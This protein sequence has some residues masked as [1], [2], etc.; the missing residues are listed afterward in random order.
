MKEFVEKLINRLEEKLYLADEEKRKADV[1]QFDRKVGYADGI[2]S[3]ID[4]I[5]ELAEENKM[6]DISDGCHTFNELYHHRAVLFAVIC[7]SYRELAWKSKLHDTG[8]MYD[9]KFIVGIETHEGQ[10]TYHYDIDPYWDIFKVKELPK[11]PRWDGHTPDEAIRRIL[12][13]GNNQGW[14]PVEDRLPETDKYIL[15]SFENLTIP[16]IGRYEEDEN[17]GAF[18]ICDDDKSCSSYGL[19]VNAW[20]LLPERYKPEEPKQIPTDHYTERFNRVI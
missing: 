8:D 13:L 2:S 20:Q 17:G 12:L 3:A 9:G 19:F 7:N 6:G 4:I 10:A 11:A 14:I 1:L 5:N 18:Y 15:L 16:G